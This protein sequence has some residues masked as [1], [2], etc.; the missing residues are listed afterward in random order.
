MSTFRKASTLQEVAGETEVQPLKQGDVRYVDLSAGRDTRDLSRLRLKLEDCVKRGDFA[1]IAFTGHRGCGKSTELYRMEHALAQ[2]FYSVH[3]FVDDSLLHAMEYPDLFLWIVESV[4]K[5]FYEASI[6][7]DDSV[8]DRVRAWFEQKV[9]ITDDVSKA[10][11]KLEA[12]VESKAGLFGLL[13]LTAKLKS[14]FMGSTERRTEIRRSL[15][16]YAN[17]LIDRMNELFDAARAGLKSVGKPVELLL[18]IDNLDRL[19]PQ[20]GREL[21][22]ENGELL[23]RPK[24]HLIYTVPLPMILAPSSI[25][26]TFD[27]FTLPM[28]KLQYPDGRRF[29]KGRDVLKKLLSARLELDS[30]FKSPAVITELIR[31]SGGSV[32]DLMRLLSYAQTDARVDYK[33]MIDLP[34]VKIAVK[35]TRIEYERTLSPVEVYFPM[36]CRVHQTKQDPMRPGEKI[37]RTSVQSAREFFS[38]LLFNGSVLEYN[39]EKCWYDVHPIVQLIDAFQETLKKL[40]NDAAET[41]EDPQ[42]AAG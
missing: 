37:D 21:F 10:E 12:G 2:E 41:A 29:D 6:P 15:K 22:L 30:I 36:L 42:P 31:M 8:I 18:V 7:V 1:K 35:K 26:N 23:K 39:G 32:R 16:N 33:A 3:L 34:S 24:V 4:A 40:S 17:D 25:N 20:V 13:S 9:Q 28:V 27:T 11:M 38:D 5:G 14:S 19:L